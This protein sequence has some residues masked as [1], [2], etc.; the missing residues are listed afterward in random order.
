MGVAQVQKI[1]NK[2]IITP[3]LNPAKTTTPFYKIHHNYPSHSPYY[4][5]S[6]RLL[7]KCQFNTERR[8]SMF[9][10]TWCQFQSVMPGQRGAD[11]NSRSHYST[12]LK[13]M[14]YDLSRFDEIMSQ[15]L[16]NEVRS[17]TKGSVLPLSMARESE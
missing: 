2:Q 8:R 17:R 16:R 9:Q 15:V 10:R 13:A 5:N 7:V 11:P 3:F 12:D 4:Y 1:S 14:T 6:L